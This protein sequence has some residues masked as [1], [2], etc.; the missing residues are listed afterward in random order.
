MSLYEDTGF[1]RSDLSTT[2]M[3]PMKT[4]QFLKGIALLTNL[5]FLKRKFF[6]HY[7]TQ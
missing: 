3:H 1:G 5:H 6:Q 7:F 2:V 4:M